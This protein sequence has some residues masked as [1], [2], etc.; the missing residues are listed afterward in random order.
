MNYQILF[1]KARSKIIVPTKKAHVNEFNLMKSTS[2]IHV[3]YQTLI[4][5]QISFACVW[6]GV[7]HV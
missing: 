6:P 2:M 4:S 5:K 1:V 7:Q 3:D